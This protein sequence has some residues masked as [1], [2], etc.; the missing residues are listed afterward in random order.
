MH[1]DCGGDTETKGVLSLSHDSFSL[2]ILHTHTHTHAC[3]K[4][5]SH[6]LNKTTV[7]SYSNLSA[8]IRG[9]EYPTDE[10]SVSTTTYHAN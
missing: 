8:Q 6:A 2:L 3:T 5:H 4:R 10:I 9:S 7:L 1:Y